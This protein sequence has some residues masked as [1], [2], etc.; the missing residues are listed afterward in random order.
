MII[1]E[2]NETKRNET[3]KK[4]GRKKGRKDLRKDWYEGKAEKEK[5][6]KE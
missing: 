6:M 3:K 4:K 2:R 5:E 1:A